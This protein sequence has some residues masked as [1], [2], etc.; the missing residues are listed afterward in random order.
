[1][2]LETDCNSKY[3]CTH[4]MNNQEVSFVCLN[5]CIYT[6]N[7]ASVVFNKNTKFLDC[8]REFFFINFFVG[9]VVSKYRF[10][11]VH[12]F[13]V[14]GMNKFNS[15]LIAVSYS[16]MFRTFNCF[17]YAFA[18]FFFLS[19]IV[20]TFFI[21]QRGNSN[22]SATVNLSVCKNFIKSPLLKSLNQI[23]CYFCRFWKD[24]KSTVYHKI[25]AKGVSC[26]QRIDANVFHFSIN[27]LLLYRHILE[28]SI[29]I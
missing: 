13:F 22:V 8:F 25:A 16:R 5:C 21:I 10:N 20:V 7:I 24:E 4:C 6:K 27:T 12:V 17:L 29:V 9:S 19:I 28:K 11:V 18:N 1:M 3:G 14:N 15:C 2:Q 23:L 26:S